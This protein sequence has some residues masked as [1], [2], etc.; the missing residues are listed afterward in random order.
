MKRLHCLFGVVAAF[1]LWAQPALAQSWQVPA[2]YVPIGRGPGV[3]GFASAAPIVN[4]VLQSSSLSANP[5][6]TA[7]PILQGAT[8]TTPGVFVQITGDTVPRARFG[9]NSTDVPSLAFGSGNAT[10]DTFL[11]RAAA[12]TWRLG[13]PD[14]AAP[15]AQT[16]SIQ[17]V[18]AGT[19]NTA[20]ANLTIAGSQGTGTGV[21]GSILFKVAPA[22]STGGTQ[23]ALSTALTLDSTLLATFAGHLRVEGVTSTGATGTG[24]LVFGTN[25]SIASLTI[26]GSFTATG[27]VTNADLANGAGYSLFGNFTGGSA[28]PQYSTIGGL[29]S[30]PSPSASDL[31]MIQ[32]QSAG[33]QLKSSPLSAITSIGTVGSVNGQTGAVVSYF[34]PQHRITLTSGTAVMK[35]STAGQT[36]VYVTP[37]SG[38]MI[39]IYDGTNMVP[40]VFPETSQATSD[41]TKSPAAVVNNS[42]YDIFC[43]VD[44]GTNR[45]TRGPPWTNDTTRSAGTALTLVNGIY[46]NNA[47]ITNGPA[48]SRGTYMGS[49]RSNGT[50]TID[51]IFGAVA[52]GGTAA[53]FSVWNAYNR[54]IAAT[55]VGDNSVN[56]TYAVATTW[57][58]AN[59]SATM[60]GSFLRGL[61]EDAVQAQYAAI[62][63]S[64]VSTL[65]A[66]GVGLDSTT[67]FVG[68]TALSNN[69][70]S[71]VFSPLPA[72]WSGIPGLGFHFVSALELNS[73]T[74]ASTWV[75]SGGVAYTQTGLHLLLRQ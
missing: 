6:F 75:G 18:V 43:W 47:S 58:A 5:T 23:N 56:W 30:K 27:L 40:T 20:G 60:R 7:T 39:P 44:S 50:A 16:L 48:A 1:L 10:R 63:T 11:E 34:P 29:T 3:T 53:N 22:G 70:G 2:F 52:S 73:T 64:G 32:D 33:G 8:T 24:P 19:S 13:A 36:T 49:I 57:R 21:G 62:G 42:I 12:A 72:E 38:D 4:G 25:P 51:Y 26:T 35:T 61:N 71:G 67:A 55:F 45:C 69:S 54:V 46:L 15:V 66:S 41:T 28:T 9:L 37:Y 68:T 14:A 17:N 65:M 59:G 31:V 74:T